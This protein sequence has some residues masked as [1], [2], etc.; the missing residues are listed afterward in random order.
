MS[1]CAFLEQVWVCIILGGDS[2]VVVV[3]RSVRFIFY[4]ID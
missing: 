4:V 1:K 3:T 2:W